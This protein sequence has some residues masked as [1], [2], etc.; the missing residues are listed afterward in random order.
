MKIHGVSRD[1]KRQRGTKNLLRW[2]ARGL[3]GQGQRDICY[4]RFG[5]HYL[6]AGGKPRMRKSVY[7]PSYSYFLSW[8]YFV[9]TFVCLNPL[10]SPLS[11][12]SS[13]SIYASSDF[14]LV[15]FGNIDISVMPLKGLFALVKPLIC[16]GRRMEFGKLWKGEATWML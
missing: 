12:S 8:F 2:Q 14:I 1:Q 3:I 5:L 11:F 7:K 15:P 13:S 9:C 4:L 6:H 10:T 16:S